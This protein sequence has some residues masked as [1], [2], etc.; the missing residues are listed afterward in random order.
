M[1]QLEDRIV[2]DVGP[3]DPQIVYRH[4]EN[5]SYDG[6]ANFSSA[7]APFFTGDLIE[8][9]G[10]FA[11]LNQETSLTLHWLIYSD[12]EVDGTFSV[13]PSTVA[14][15][16][17]SLDDYAGEFKL[18]TQGTAEL[19]I[20]AGQ[21]VNSLA[22]FTATEPGR[23]I[24]VLMAEDSDG[25]RVSFSTSVFEV[26]A[27]TQLTAEITS[28]DGPLVVGAPLTVEGGASGAIDSAWNIYFDANDDSLFDASEIVDVIPAQYADINNV[29]TLL[30]LSYTPASVGGYRIELAVATVDASAADSVD[31]EVTSSA[32][33]NGVLYAGASAGGS[34]IFISPTSG[35]VQVNVDGNA[36]TYTDPLTQVV[37][38]GG[39]GNDWVV[40]GNV[41]VSAW[42]FGGDGND[43]IAGG[44]GD[45]VLIGGN[46]SDTLIGNG[47]RDLLIGGHGSDLIVGNA[48]D[49]ILIAGYTLVDNDA[50]ALAAI[51]NIWTNN[52]L[53][54]AARTDA[55][56]S[57]HL[58]N[59]VNVFD[60]DAMDLMAGLGGLDWYFANLVRDNEPILNRDFTLGMNAQELAQYEELIDELLP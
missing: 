48:G 58:V 12:T 4:S 57:G 1:E 22:S 55:L 37:V 60:D 30:P 8:F 10:E 59:E 19:P 52:G 47:G 13:E 18:E 15:E 29:T 53:T 26:N 23:F 36:V 27:N 34:A 9:N 32:V 14:G 24:G 2:F 20:L 40:I 17:I 25:N 50:A 5:L 28:V 39:A 44:G 56:R 11:V 38:Y 3:I 16:Y 49:D 33:A 43:V 42:V 35:G 46:G 41:E 7:N 21:T 51:I 31:F 6:F 54:F 45:D